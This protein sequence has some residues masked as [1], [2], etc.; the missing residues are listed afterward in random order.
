MDSDES[1][2]DKGL[3]GRMGKMKTWVRQGYKPPC[4]SSHLV[5]Q[6]GGKL[7]SKPFV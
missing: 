3:G 1:V 2:P 5:A 6:E 7:L 4:K